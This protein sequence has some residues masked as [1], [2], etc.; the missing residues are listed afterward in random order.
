MAICTILESTKSQHQLGYRL[1]TDQK[2]EPI[3]IEIFSDYV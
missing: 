1:K 3:L 2:E